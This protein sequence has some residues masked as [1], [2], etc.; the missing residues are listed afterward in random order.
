MSGLWCDGQRIDSKS[1]EGASCGHGYL[2][3]SSLAL[4]GKAVAKRFNQLQK[5]IS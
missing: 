3:S 5:R 2:G 4:R 1:R